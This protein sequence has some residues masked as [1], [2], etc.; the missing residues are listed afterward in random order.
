MVYEVRY[1]RKP[2]GRFKYDEYD[3]R[4]EALDRVRELAH[5]GTWKIEVYDLSIF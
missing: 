3:E 2:R 1:Q 4:F 5:A